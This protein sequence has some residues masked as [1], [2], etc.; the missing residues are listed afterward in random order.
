MI[1]W[2]SRV[3]RQH[4]FARWDLSS[5]SAKDEGF[6]IV[7]KNFSS[8]A[9]LEWWWYKPN[10]RYIMLMDN[11]LPSPIVYINSNY[12]QP[13]KDFLFVVCSAWETF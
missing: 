3:N 5:E 9:L 12:N 7:Y 8:L 13:N 6:V 4:K 2:E 10:Y 11:N 1:F